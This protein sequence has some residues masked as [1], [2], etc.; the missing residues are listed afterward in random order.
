MQSFTFHNPTKII[1]GENTIGKL[2]EETPKYG[3]KA[4]LVSGKGAIKKNG[5]YDQVIAALRQAGTEFAEFSGVQANPVLSHTRAGIELAKKENVDMVIAA[6]GGSVLDEAKAICAGASAEND[7]WDFYTGKA[8]PQS[9]LPLLTVLTVAATG[10]EM[11]GGTVITNE[12]THEKYGWGHPLLFPKVSILDPSTTITLGAEYTAYAAVDAATHL[13]ESY[14]T[15][16]DTDTLI[17][18][19]YVEGLIRTI[20]DVT[21]TMIR[22]PDDYQAR[23]VFMW[24]ATLAWNNIA[25]SGVGHWCTPNHLIGHSMS[26]LFGTPHGAS[27]SI[28]LSGWLVWYSGESGRNGAKLAQFGKRVF[29][30]NEPVTVRAA[31]LAIEALR[32]WFHRIHS[33]TKPADIGVDDAGLL[34]VAENVEFCNP[35]WGMPQY[36]KDL[37][38]SILKLCR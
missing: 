5:V 27:L 21:E 19:R 34:Q 13:M 26:A 12:E 25:P 18:D 31:E 15:C 35:H 24:A 9:A 28:A 36:N 33:P 22:T 1:F 11:N 38:A 3:K 32:G 23:A 2:A 7:V 10:S 6:G 4:L 17:Q 37:V 20:V 29:D 14:F 8:E 30:I 16:E